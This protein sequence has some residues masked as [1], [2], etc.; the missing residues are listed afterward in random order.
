[1]RIKGKLASWKARLLSNGGKL[2]LIKHELSSMP[3]QLLSVLNIPTKVLLDIQRLFLIS[4]WRDR[5]GKVKKKWITWGKA[6]K[7]V[8]DEGLGLGSLHEV[9]ALLMNFTWKF[10]HEKSVGKP[11]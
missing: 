4:F 7:P 5:A 2:V 6:R 8:E 10:L 1:M 3:L 11:F 9:K